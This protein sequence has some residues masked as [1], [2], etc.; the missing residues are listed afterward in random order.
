V[1]LFGARGGVGVLI[2]MLALVA[3]G[4]IGF[5]FMPP[6]EGDRLYATLTMPEGIPVEDTARAAEQIERAALALKAELDA[7]SPD[8]PSLVQNILTSVGQTGVRG[9][10]PQAGVIARP[11]VSHVAEVAIALVPMRERRGVSAGELAG[12]W[13][14]LTGAV[15]DSVELGFSADVFSAGAAIS[16][17]LRGRDVDDL[18][19]VA[20]LCAA[21]SDA[22]TACSTSAT[23]S[24]PVNRKC[25]SR[26][27]RTPATS[28]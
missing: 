5:Q 9:G 28:G 8:R 24:A 22:S 20:T 13:R 19:E 26:C 25:S 2:L 11:A 17:E 23:A 14:E 21:N 3:S 6:I 7:R 12:R 18:R 1:A 27:D 4:R 10:G 16:I 15:T